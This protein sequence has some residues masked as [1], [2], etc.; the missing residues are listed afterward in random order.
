M[1][2]LQFSTLITA[3]AS[4]V[5]VLLGSGITILYNLLHNRTEKKQRI[6]ESKKAAYE[7]L[8]FAIKQWRSCQALQ[9]SLIPFKSE[10]GDFEVR[11]LERYLRED[12]ECTQNLLSCILQSQ[13]VANDFARDAIGHFHDVFDAENS[14]GPVSDAYLDA[15]EC[16]FYALYI[17]LHESKLPKPKK[18]KPTKSA[19]R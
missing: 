13:L 16:L 4:I 8:I 3:I 18:Q 15:E 5:G 14:N 1:T 2:D 9:N 10:H 11:E 17:D 19:K 7:S 12:T 6:F